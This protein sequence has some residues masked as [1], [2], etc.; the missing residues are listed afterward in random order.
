MMAERNRLRL[1][2]SNSNKR[3]SS[4][5]V[6]KPRTRPC[7]N[8]LKSW[9]GSLAGTAGTAASLLRATGCRS[10]GRSPGQGASAANRAGRAAGSPGTR[11]RPCAGP[12]GRTMSRIIIR[13]TVRAAAR[14]CRP[15]TGM[16]AMSQDRSSTCRSRAPSRPRNTALTVAFAVIAARRHGRRFPQA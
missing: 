12:T 14:R 3:T 10:R 1:C 5:P 4:S 13:R 15:R 8:V 9:S 6:C 2:G 11:A 16:E 7:G